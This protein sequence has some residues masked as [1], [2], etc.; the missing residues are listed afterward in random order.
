MY[1]GAAAVLLGAGLFISSPS[2]VL[3]APG[4]LLLMHLFVVLHEEAAL[5]ARFGDDYLRYKSTV[6]RWMIKRPANAP[7]GVG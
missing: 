1:L 7:R 2:V 3:L 4:F 6:H 5:A